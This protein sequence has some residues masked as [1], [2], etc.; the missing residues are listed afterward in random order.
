MGCTSGGGRDGGERFHR[1]RVENLGGDGDVGDEE[2]GH[3]HPKPSGHLL[4]LGGFKAK[5]AKASLL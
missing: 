3:C 5:V 4:Q 1:I 2:E